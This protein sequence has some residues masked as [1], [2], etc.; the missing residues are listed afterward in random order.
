[1]KKVLLIG[2]L[3]LASIGAY[4]QKGEIS[5]LGNLGYQTDY[6]RF[7]IGVQ[8]RYNIINHLRIAPDVTFFFPKDK[9]T[10]F[11]VNI[12]FHYVFDLS[13]SGLSVYPLAGFGMQNNH[14]G[15][16]DYMP[17]SINSTDFAFNLG[18]GISY[19]IGPKSYLNAEGK[20]M[21]GDNDCAVF[22]LGYGYKF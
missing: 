9:V 1:M 13:T 18:G 5:V 21:F 16:R 14:A 3:I 11:D 19:N 12:N 8:G 15:K 10:G 22:M 20:F 2:A 7:G 4:S 17:K 6:E